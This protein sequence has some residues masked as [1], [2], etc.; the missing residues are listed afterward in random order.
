MLN[1]KRN[2]V[3]LTTTETWTLSGDGKTL[4]VQR[5]SESPR[6]TQTSTLVFNKQ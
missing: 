1:I 5:T 3:T 4:T 2:E 6:G